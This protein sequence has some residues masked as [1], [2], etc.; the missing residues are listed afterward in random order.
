M[1]RLQFQWEAV[2]HNGTIGDFPTSVTHWPFVSG[3]VSCSRSLLQLVFTAVHRCS[4]VL[5]HVEFLVVGHIYCILD[6][7]RQMFESLHTAIFYTLCYG[8]LLA[9]EMRI[10]LTCKNE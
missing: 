1:V 6:W 4:G 2:G 9:Q 10:Q 7:Y 3:S 8:Y 5:P